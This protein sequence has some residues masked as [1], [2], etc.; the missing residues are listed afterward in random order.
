L[1]RKIIAL[2]E[3]ASAADKSA[4]SLKA[5]FE[6]QDLERE[7]E[8]KHTI[9][10]QIA[11]CKYDINGCDSEQADD[12]GEANEVRISLE[13][14]L[15]KS[16]DNKPLREQQGTIVARINALVNQ[17]NQNNSQIKESNPDNEKEQRELVQKNHDLQN[18]CQKI[19]ELVTDGLKF[20]SQVVERLED[21]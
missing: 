8:F 5:S 7:T 11:G 18:E 12:N 15:C 4:K 2:N 20:A 10:D 21:L 19:T 9:H 13:N 6:N 3:A 17:F 1:A 16:K 14:S